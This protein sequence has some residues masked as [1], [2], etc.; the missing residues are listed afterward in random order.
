MTVLISKLSRATAMATLEGGLKDVDLGDGGAG[1][2][3][4]SGGETE[5][6]GAGAGGGGGRKPVAAM[7]RRFSEAAQCLERAHAAAEMPFF[8]FGGGAPQSRSSTPLQ[9]E[10]RFREGVTWNMY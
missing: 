1:G 8:G 10:T 9:L 3:R 6:A 7:V 2:G 5:S 4:G